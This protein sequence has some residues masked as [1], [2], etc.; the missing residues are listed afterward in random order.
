MWGPGF[1]VLYRLDWRWRH[2]QQCRYG[3]QWRILSFLRYTRHCL[4]P[5]RGLQQSWLLLQQP[6]C[7][8]EHG[9]RNDWRNLPSR[10]L[11]G[12]RWSAAAL[13]LDV[14]L[15][16]A[17]LQERNLY[18]MWQF[19]RLLLSHGQWPGSLQDRQRV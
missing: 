16:R 17:Y 10:A 7:R 12:L 15:R 4:L 18:F 14:L 3:L 8:R 19:G 11:F 5:R 9:L 1:R 13:L 2:M 6:M